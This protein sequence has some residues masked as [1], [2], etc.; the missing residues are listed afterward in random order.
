[1]ITNFFLSASYMSGT[2]LNISFK[3]FHSPDN[4]MRGV[5]LC[6]SFAGEEIEAQR[7]LVQILMARKR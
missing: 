7:D 2:V 5:L 1:M 4:L 3:L 6:P